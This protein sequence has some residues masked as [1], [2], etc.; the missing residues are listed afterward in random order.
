MQVRVLSW[1]LKINIMFDA[2][3]KTK[4]EKELESYLQYLNS[5]MAPFE[6]RKLK[7]L[8]D[9]AIKARATS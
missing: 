8:I 4:E 5:A 7:N 3:E 9:K 1:L 6:M 2:N